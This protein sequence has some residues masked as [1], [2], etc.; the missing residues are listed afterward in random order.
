MT[1]FH[2][3]HL[4]LGAELSPNYIE[5]SKVMAYNSFFTWVGGGLDDLGRAQL[6]LPVDAGVP[7]TACS[8]PNPGPDVRAGVSPIGI[9][10]VLFASAWFTRDRI[11]FLPQPGRD[12]T[13][14]FSTAE[15][16][17]DV[18]KA[19]RNVNYV[20]LLIGYFFLSMMLGPDARACACY[21][22]T[23]YWELTS[24][25]LR[26]FVIGSFAGYATAFAFAARM[27]GRY[28]KKANG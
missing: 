22:N 23:F 16:F 19:L 1:F 21:T 9:V 7:E 26:W 18:W 4:A 25:Q 27:H 20:W 2:T 8:T 28:D 6:L 15:F 14:A 17:R 24:E 5:R 11:P 13:Q 3:P 10:V 12:D